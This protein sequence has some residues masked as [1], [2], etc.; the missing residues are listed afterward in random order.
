MIACLL[1]FQGVTPREASISQVT[2][3]RISLSTRG[4]QADASQTLLRELVVSI[5][6]NIR[7]RFR[8]KKFDLPLDPSS[9]T[10]PWLSHIC[11]V[12]A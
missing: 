11:P 9:Q 3:V 10:H 2:S 4:L 1:G 12:S 8:S 7:Y 6:P 5:S